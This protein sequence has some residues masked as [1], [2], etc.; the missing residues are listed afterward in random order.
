MKFLF[1]PIFKLLDIY[2]CILTKYAVKRSRFRRIFLH[3]PSDR[4]KIRLFE[5]GNIFKVGIEV[6]SYDDKIIIITLPND[7][8]EV[9]IKNINATS[10]EIAKER[11][12]ILQI[13]QKHF[14]QNGWQCKIIE[15]NSRQSIEG[16]APKQRG[17]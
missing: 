13:T 10:L 17:V 14:L 1:Y 6:V 15:Q 4:Y 9:L 12:R 16:S 3:D 8:S 7:D 11:A 5:N 2:N